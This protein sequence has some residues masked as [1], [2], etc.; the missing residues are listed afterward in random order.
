MITSDLIF[1]AR[2]KVRER[3][4][5]A[6]KEADFYAEKMVGRIDKDVRTAV[7]GMAMRNVEDAGVDG[8]KQAI[9][10]AIEAGLSPD[11]LEAY[12]VAGGVYK[13]VID[14]H[15]KDRFP[16]KP[17]YK[18]SRFVDYVVETPVEY[19]YPSRV[20]RSIG[21][22]TVKNFTPS[23]TLL[24]RANIASGVLLT[25]EL[26]EEKKVWVADN[27]EFS[28]IDAAIEHIDK[29]LNQFA[30]SY[31]ALKEVRDRLQESYDKA[32]V[33]GEYAE[34]LDSV[35][36]D[37]AKILADSGSLKT[38][39]QKL[40]KE[41]KKPTRK[42]K[43]EAA[44]AFHLHRLLVSEYL[45]AFQFSLMRTYKALGIKFFKWQLAEDHYDRLG[46]WGMERDW[47]DDLAQ[48]P[49][50][51]NLNKKDAKMIRQLAA[52]PDTA[53]YLYADPDPRPYWDG[54]RWEDMFSEPSLGIYYSLTTRK[55][56]TFAHK[57]RIVTSRG[58][59]RQ[60]ITGRSKRA[61]YVPPHP[62]CSCLVL[63]IYIPP[64]ALPPDTPEDYSFL[65]TGK[66]AIAYMLDIAA[67]DKVEQ[68]LLE[69]SEGIDQGAS[70]S[71]VSSILEP[72]LGGVLAGAYAG[73]IM[74]D[75]IVALYEA[76]DDV[77][78]K[79]A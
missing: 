23:P 79:A 24:E 52:N 51:V 27:I 68:M 13:T 19:G 67:H 33:K 73:L 57:W 35:D 9:E 22:D 21:S 26:V 37:L 16:F 59:R 3:A 64:E 1:D 4:D 58:V 48:S 32:K 10:I 50:E 66:N 6:G 20:P 54:S 31:R 30:V 25:A 43:K 77:M 15:N 72:F 14:L 61:L 7:R 74:R 18:Y 45:R 12:N 34:R 63:P 8:V 44:A 40:E 5:R 11:V 38:E 76:V 47:C 28:S 49:P 39:K 60:I 78:L 75:G 53:I 36:K 17:D 42:Q 62:Y 41:K 2:R 69:L 29:N 55:V 65:R 56:T 71:W 70:K 46:K